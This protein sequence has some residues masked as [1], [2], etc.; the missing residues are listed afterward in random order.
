VTGATGEIPL[1]VKNTE[2]DAGVTGKIL[3]E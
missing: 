2:N 1:E 3:V